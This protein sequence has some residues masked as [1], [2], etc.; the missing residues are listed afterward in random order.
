M[1]L[2]IKETTMKVFYT[3]EPLIRTMSSDSAGMAHYQIYDVTGMQ[4]DQVLQGNQIYAG[5]AYCP[6]GHEDL[7]F[8]PMLRTL[9]ENQVTLLGRLDGW[10]Q[11]SCLFLQSTFAYN[12]YFSV[13]D[14]DSSLNTTEDYS[15]V[16]DT[17][18][19]TAY[20]AGATSVNNTGSY[21]YPANLYPEREILQGQ[22]FNLTWRNPTNAGEMQTYSFGFEYCYAT[23]SNPGDPEYLVVQ[24]HT[25]DSSVT[26]QSFRYCGPADWQDWADGAS[27]VRWGRFYLY[28]SEKQTYT[29]LTPRL[30]PRW[31]DEP[32]TVYLYWLNSL[33]GIEFVRGRVIKSIE[34]E[35]ST[36]ESNDGIDMYRDGW[37]T[38]IYSQHK[39]ND[40]VFNTRIMTDETSPAVADVCGARYAWLY[41]PGE[42]QPWNTVRVT[43]A[44]A[45]VK[46]AA[47]EG[48]RL[49][50]YTWNIEDSVKAKT[51]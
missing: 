41:F 47:D 4:D 5:M 35:D 29:Y 42:L 39:W 36:Y 6:D 21:P 51:I 19:I 7:D 44:K 20:E 1:T 24:R 40:Y 18:G 38:R 46:K 32:D 43:D 15:I 28:L 16:Y 34:H 8:M 31:C 33:G 27:N 11:Q 45:T 30:Y 26:G 37:G 23:R 25:L 3:S 48:K 17:R 2:K 22:Y 14:L 9:I 10:N 13:I 49:F 50:N 12:T